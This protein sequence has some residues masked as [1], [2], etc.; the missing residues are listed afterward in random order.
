MGFLASHVAGLKSKKY[1]MFWPNVAEIYAPVVTKNLGL[2]PFGA[3][4]GVILGGTLLVFFLSD[5]SVLVTGLIL[6][7]PLAL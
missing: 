3:L 4:W 6:F 5:K 7:Y 1:E 2:G